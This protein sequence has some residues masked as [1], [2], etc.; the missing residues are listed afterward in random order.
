LSDRSFAFQ[1]S[2]SSGRGEPEVALYLVNHVGFYKRRLWSWGNEY[3]SLGGMVV[4]INA[5]LSTIPIFYLSYMKMMV[6]VWREVV[7]IQQNFL[8]GGLSKRRRI[9]WVKWE[10]ICKPK[11]EGGLGIKDLRL[12]NLSLLAK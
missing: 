9:S 6:K 10:D 4:L 1:V 11:I 7:S 5:F 12:V 2:W 3:R 8:L